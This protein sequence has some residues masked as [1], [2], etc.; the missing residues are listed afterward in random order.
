VYSL[1]P[2]DRCIGAGRKYRGIV[3]NFNGSGIRLSR[4]SQI[5]LKICGARA[6]AVELD[7]VGRVRQQGFLALDFAQARAV[8]VEKADKVVDVQLAIDG[9][10]DWQR[11]VHEIPRIISR[12]PGRTDGCLASK[13]FGINVNLLR[14]VDIRARELRRV[15]GA[16][17][18]AQ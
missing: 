13:L 15:Y 3:A 14:R 10:S 1:V 5:N 16:L 2:I 4:V 11:H 8:A 9:R 12:D 6:H 17:A 7:R 18:R